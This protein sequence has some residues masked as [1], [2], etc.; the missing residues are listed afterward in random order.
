MNFSILFL[1]GGGGGRGVTIQPTAG[2]FLD[3]SSV[4]SLTTSSQSEKPRNGLLRGLRPGGGRGP[5]KL[6]LRVVAQGREAGLLHAS[7]GETQEA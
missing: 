5:V 2:S 4:A 7:F 1:R 3:T 6:G